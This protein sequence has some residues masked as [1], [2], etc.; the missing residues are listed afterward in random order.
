MEEHLLLLYFNKKLCIHIDGVSKT[1][2]LKWFLQSS[3]PNPKLV[4]LAC[5]VAF[6]NPFCL[7]QG[8]QTIGIAKCLKWPQIVA[9][10]NL[11]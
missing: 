10:N 3:E 1:E 8:E 4:Q 11:S 2:E 7:K 5:R 6:S 9:H